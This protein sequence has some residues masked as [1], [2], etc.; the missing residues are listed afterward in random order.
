M[1]N[2]A[3]IFIENNFKGID[4]L[5]NSLKDWKSDKEK[6]IET[7]KELY[8]FITYQ[9]KLLKSDKDTI[10][11]QMEMIEKLQI[12]IANLNHRIYVLQ[13]KK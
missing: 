6:A 4:D 5:I 10:K 3:K 8:D 1:T 13:L 12:K 2:L 7:I 11:E 9:N